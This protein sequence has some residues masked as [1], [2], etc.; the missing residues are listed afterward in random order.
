MD[1][2]TLSQKHFKQ[3]QAALD[4]DDSSSHSNSRL[5]VHSK[6]NRALDQQR[7]KSS[8]NL[9][10]QKISQFSTLDAFQRNS[11]KQDLFCTSNGGETT[12]QSD[13]LAQHLTRANQSFNFGDLAQ[14]LKSL[15]RLIRYPA[16]IKSKE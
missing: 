16:N 7:T 14:Q 4:L 9:G 10:K 12:L 5:L 3:F 1:P 2:S 15:L 13:T 11:S 6:S 8:Q